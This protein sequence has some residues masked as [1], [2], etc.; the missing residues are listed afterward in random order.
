MRSAL[1]RHYK[2]KTFPAG[3]SF[4]RWRLPT[5]LSGEPARYSGSPTRRGNQV[6]YH[7]GIRSRV[8]RNTLANAN[9]VGDW[10]IYAGFAQR[11]IGH[12]TNCIYSTNVGTVVM[13]RMC[14]IDC[15]S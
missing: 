3:T 8:S 10:R 7:L 12:A 11:L 14:G 2:I 9:Q 15:H 4:S 13:W 5:H 6:L 1:P